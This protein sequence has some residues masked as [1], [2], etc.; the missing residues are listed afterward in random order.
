MTL[1]LTFRYVVAFLLLNLLVSE[2]HELAHIATGGLICGCYGPRTFNVWQT[3]TACAHPDLYPL[4]SVAGPLGSYALMWLGSLLLFSPSPRRQGLGFSLLFA[5]LPFA[6]I[7]TLLMGGGD[8][9]VIVRTLAAPENRLLYRLLMTA[10]VLL[11]AGIPMAVAYRRVRNHRPWA[12]VAGFAVGPL[13]FQFL[14]LF[15]LLNG[16]L[17]RGLLAEPWLMGTPLLVTIHTAIAAVL[18]VAFARYLPTINAA[19]SA[20]PERRAW[21]AV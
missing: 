3:C 10:L 21:A 20:S 19:V 12:W 6:R 16:L 17:K 4:P 2:L 13:L 15:Q 9:M 7:F 18:L 5:A 8:E 11:V 14:Y 1:R